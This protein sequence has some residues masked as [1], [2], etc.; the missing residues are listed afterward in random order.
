MCSDQGAR[1]QDESSLVAIHAIEVGRRPSP[2][3]HGGCPAVAGTYGRR[4]GSRSSGPRPR[5]YGARGGDLYQLTYKVGGDR[6]V[7]LT[8]QAETHVRQ[9]CS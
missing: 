2:E 5:G 9:S 6:D 4:S 8:V 7:L 1:D 3:W